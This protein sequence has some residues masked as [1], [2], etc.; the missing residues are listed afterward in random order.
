MKVPRALNGLRVYQWMQMRERESLWN[1]LLPVLRG[2]RLF[3]RI[4]LPRTA[5]EKRDLFVS[6]CTQT[7]QSKGTATLPLSTFIHENRHTIMLW[8]SI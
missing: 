6:K 2:D 1:T 8:R 3:P 7:Y 5:C 4:S